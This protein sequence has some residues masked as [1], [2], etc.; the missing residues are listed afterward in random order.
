M[1]RVSTEY[2]LSLLLFSESVLRWN[3][4]AWT[5]DADAAST[6]QRQDDT[7]R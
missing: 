5:I 7:V 6:T 1:G 2:E 3:L 4:W